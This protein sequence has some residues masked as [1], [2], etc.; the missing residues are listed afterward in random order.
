MQDKLSM[1]EGGDC[2]LVGKNGDL[3]RCRVLSLKLH[4]I[5]QAFE[6]AG[7]FA[8]PDEYPGNSQAEAIK[9]SI[10]YAAGGNKHHVTAY[11][12]S[13]PDPLIPLIRELDQCVMLVSIAGVR[14]HP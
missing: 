13:M 2:E 1:Y 7:F 4:K 12:N 6:Q 3:H 10:Y 5:E 8:L 11:S 14:P 9:Y